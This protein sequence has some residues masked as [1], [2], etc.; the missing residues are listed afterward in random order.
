MIN[1]ILDFLASLEL[2]VLRAI[3]RC[4][5]IERMS[6]H[7]EIKRLR[8]AKGWSHKRLAD[9]VSQAEGRARPLS[10]QTVQQW[11]REPT[12]SE[13]KKSTAPNRS[14]LELVASLLGTSATALLQGGAPSSDPLDGLSGHEGM[15]LAYFRMVAPEK[16]AEL[17][18]LVQERAAR[19]EVAPG[20]AK[21]HE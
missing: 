20:K 12:A 21:R 17:L 7:S 8:Q 3:D 6:I 19:Y 1:N 18:L 5:D 15:L 9:E 13:T 14:R 2:L 16:R 10:W 11:E 4:A